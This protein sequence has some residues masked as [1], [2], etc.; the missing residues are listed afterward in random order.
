MGHR[1]AAAHRVLLSRSRK[2][3][4]AACAARINRILCGRTRRVVGHGRFAGNGRRPGVFITTE[5]RIDRKCPQQGAPPPEVR[6]E[7]ACYP[8][9][10][11]FGSARARIPAHR[12]SAPEGTGG[13]RSMAASPAR[14]EHGNRE[15]AHR[16]RR[17]PRLANRGPLSGGRSS[18]CR[19][20]VTGCPSIT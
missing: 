12:A 5:G 13:S 20:R 3:M 8:L 15:R 18:R 14:G 4:V 17:F 1:I 11:D 7:E 6:R 2:A 19:D 9:D 10:L 16:P